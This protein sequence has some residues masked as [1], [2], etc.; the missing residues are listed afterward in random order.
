[1]VSLGFFFQ[2]SDEVAVV[3]EDIEVVV[4]V[5]AAEVAVVLYE[6]GAGPESCIESIFLPFQEEEGIG[7]NLEVTDF[8][9]MGGEYE[10][11]GFFFYQEGEPDE[12]FLQFGVHVGEAL[13]Y[14]NHMIT[15]GLQAGEDGAEGE[16]FDG[17]LGESVGVDV[18]EI[19][20]G[21]GECLFVFEENGVRLG[22]GAVGGGGLCD[23]AMG[24]PGFWDEGDHI[25]DRIIQDGKYFGNHG[26]IDV[27]ESAHADGVTMEAGEGK[28]ELNACPPNGS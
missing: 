17:A 24:N 25:F 7:R 2:E 3:G 10:L 11:V 13:I 5:V 23:D 21:D 27:C 28:P 8:Y 14:E 18:G 22:Q 16:G 15:N 4:F 1:M 9:V 19:A 20:V 12:I 26:D 6:L